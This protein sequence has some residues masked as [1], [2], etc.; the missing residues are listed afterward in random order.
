MRLVDRRYHAERLLERSGAAAKKSGGSSET[1]E[2]EVKRQRLGAD[3]LQ[4]ERT[5]FE[6]L[7]LGGRAFVDQMLVGMLRERPPR[8]FAVK[9]SP[10]WLAA[11]TWLDAE[12]HA[13]EN[14]EDTDVGISFGSR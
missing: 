8:A 5:L 14:V 3:R 1:V 9:T 6:L 11:L 13:T 4:L 10:R 12:E 2:V 7:T